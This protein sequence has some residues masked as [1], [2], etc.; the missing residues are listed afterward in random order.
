MDTLVHVGRGLLGILAFIGIAYA[1]SENRRA[2]PWRL[3]G[4]GLVFQFLCG[5]LVL[6]IDAVRAA[7]DWVGQMFVSILDF[8]R[9]LH[10]LDVV[11]LQN[12]LHF[13]SFGAQ[14]AINLA[15]RRQIRLEGDELLAL[16]YRKGNASLRGQRV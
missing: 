8:N 1:C 2:I 12:E 6:K 13:H 4:A 5:V 10:G 14:L 3:V 9:T 15:T 7:V 11:K 16:Q